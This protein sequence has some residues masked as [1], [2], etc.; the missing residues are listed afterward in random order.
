[1]VSVKTPP[2]TKL[3][4]TR[5]FSGSVILKIANGLFLI[6]GNGKAINRKGKRPKARAIRDGIKAIL[7]TSRFIKLKKVMFIKNL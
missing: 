1:M 2:M 3:S 4:I 7:E 5:M 6:L